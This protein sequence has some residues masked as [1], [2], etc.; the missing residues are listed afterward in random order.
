MSVIGLAGWAGK[1][2]KKQSIKIGYFLNQR[3]FGLSK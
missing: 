3:D 2:Q 1:F